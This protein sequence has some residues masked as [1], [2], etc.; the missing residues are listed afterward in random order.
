MPEATISDLGLFSAGRRRVLENFFALSSLQAANYILPLLTMPYLIRVLGA[1]KFGLVNFAG[2]FV[3]YF[4]IVTDYGF[5]LSATQDVSVHRNDPEKIS[6]IFSAVL[7]IKVSLMILSL[8][9][10]SGVLWFVP[11]FGDESALYLFTFAGVVG[12]LLFPSWFFQ[13]IE[14]MKYITLLNV[15]SK[16]LFTVSVFALVRRP[17]DYVYVPLLNSAGLVVAGLLSLLVAVRTFGVKLRLPG[18]TEIRNQLR[19]GW[20]IFISAVTIN[21][22]TGTRVF[23]VGLF[24]NNAITGYYALAEKLMQ[25]VQTVPLASLLGAIHPRLSSIHLNDPER[26]L[27]IMRRLQR[28][29]TLGYTALLPVLFIFAP[30][31][32]RLVTGGAYEET[33]LS[34][35]LLLVAVLFINANAFRIQFMLIS[36]R[37][38]LY[39]RIHLVASALGTLLVFVGTYF[40]S[41]LGPSIAIMAVSLLVLILTIKHT[42]KNTARHAS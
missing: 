20:H 19:L 12:G 34:F 7:L 24:T 10:L 27:R 13:G 22:Y 15:L 6:E 11:R 38:E 23:A 41:Y 18:T 42:P 33:I 28:Y 21:A 29:T 8:V 39:A 1:E 32:V 40:F 26:G 2:A 5:N 36:G 30:Q 9:V 25:M 35:R 37:T 17:E 16:F 14:S 3:Q 4:G 31:I